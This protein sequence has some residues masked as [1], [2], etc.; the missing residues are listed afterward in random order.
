MTYSG[1]HNGIQNP[2]SQR[3]S[4]LPYGTGNRNFPVL[5]VPKG[6]RTGKEDTLKQYEVR[7]MFGDEKI[8]IQGNAH[9]GGRNTRFS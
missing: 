1:G 6:V 9:A 4:R 5:S 2:G 8:V 7:Q 3:K